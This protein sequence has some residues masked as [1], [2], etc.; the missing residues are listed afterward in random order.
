MTDLSQ[1]A[2]ILASDLNATIQP[3]E[4][5]SDNDRHFNI[6]TDDL[7]IYVSRKGWGAKADFIEVGV[8]PN[9]RLEDND[10]NYR[11]GWPTISLNGTR[12]VEALVADIKR[13]VINS[14]ATSSALLKYRENVEAKRS[15]ENDLG[16]AQQRLV[17]LPNVRFARDR[18][19]SS[20][21]CDFYNYGGSYFNGRVNSDGQVTFERVGSVS[22][23]KAERILKILGE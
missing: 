12:P 14:E 11:L 13:R 5:A 8:A 10:C 2:N 1:L 17:A 23:D 7:V 9:G 6:K 16:R 18:G 4:F 19:T 15:R 21:T 3:N 22:M 20:W